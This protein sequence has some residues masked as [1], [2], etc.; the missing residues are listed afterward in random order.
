MVENDVGLVQAWWR[1]IDKKWRQPGL[2]PD[3]DG[4]IENDASLVQDWRGWIDRKQRKPDEKNGLIENDA[5]LVQVT[6]FAGKIKSIRSSRKFQEE[7]NN[8]KMHD[9]K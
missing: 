7:G 8:K 9:R 5:S 6:S 4:L 3:E 2:K 1:W